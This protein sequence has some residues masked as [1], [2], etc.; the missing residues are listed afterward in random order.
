MVERAFLVTALLRWLLPPHVTLTPGVRVRWI[1]GGGAA[2]VGVGALAV[3]SALRWAAPNALPWGPSTIRALQVAVPLVAGVGTALAVAGILWPGVRRRPVVGVMLGVLVA[4]LSHP[5]AWGV[6]ALLDG[7][8]VW[9]TGW[10][11]ASWTSLRA[12]GWATAPLCAAGG[13]WVGRRF[14]LAG[15]H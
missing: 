14:S 5:A 4:V 11:M 8:A 15:G 2:A 10:V 6:A 9:D 1:G 7:G 13:Y 12:V 3:G